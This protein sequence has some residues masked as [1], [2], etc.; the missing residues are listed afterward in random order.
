MPI[1]MGRDIGTGATGC[2]VSCAGAEDEGSS[3]ELAAADG[4]CSG[5]DGSLDD[6]SAEAGSDVAPCDEAAGT[7]DCS[8]AV[9]S[10]EEPSSLGS[11]DEGSAELGSLD[12]ST[13]STSI[14]GGGA[15][16]SGPL[17]AGQTSRSSTAEWTATD[18]ATC[19]A[20]GRPRAG[21]PISGGSGGSTLDTTRLHLLH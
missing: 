15:A 5:A 4:C 13:S 19:Q 1:T 8:V 21:A 7:D 11:A 2:G 18:A 9:G 20:I 17:R 3:A 16:S 10:S 12:G 6:A 14:T